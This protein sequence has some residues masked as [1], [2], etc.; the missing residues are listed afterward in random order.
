M[1]LRG[2]LPQE[3]FHHDDVHV[4]SVHHPMLFEYADFAKSAAAIESLAGFIAVERMQY[5][6]VETA[7]LSVF[8]E[9]HQEFAADALTATVAPNVYREVGDVGVGAA[10]GERIE[11]CPAGDLAAVKGNQYDV[12]SVMLR[13]P[14]RYFIG[15]LCIALE[16]CD[17]IFDPFVINLADRLQVIAR[18]ASQIRIFYQPR[19][20]SRQVEATA[21]RR[22]FCLAA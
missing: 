5:D 19:S 20:L 7:E 10:I 6:F 14:T 12:A 2:T 22:V 17:P 18:G 15:R 13:P 21:A 11:R 3:P 8:H 4:R 9:P 16:R 1:H